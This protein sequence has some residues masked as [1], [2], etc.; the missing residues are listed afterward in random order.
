MFDSG[1]TFF[2]FFLLYFTVLVLP[3]INM[4]PPRV[5]R[6][7]NPEPLSHLPPRAISLGHPSALAFHLKSLCFL[8]SRPLSPL[9]SKTCTLHPTEPISRLT[10]LYTYFT[11][12]WSA[13]FLIQQ[14]ACPPFPSLVRS[15]LGISP[16]DSRGLPIPSKVRVELH[17]FLWPFPIYIRNALG[18]HY[19]INIVSFALRKKWYKIYSWFSGKLEC[20]CE[21]S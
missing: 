8:V 1:G 9:T 20:Y 17:I 13:S 10:W 14:L 19:V 7:P 21:A 11:F 18:K 2:S 4:N 12:E 3:Y 6:V 5:T 16:T 15:Y